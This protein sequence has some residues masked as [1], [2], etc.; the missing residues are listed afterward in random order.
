MPD[1]LSL[2]E[3]ERRFLAQELHDGMTQSLLQVNMQ[4]SICK[5]YL[6]MG[7]HAE[8]EKELD[9]LESQVH[10][11]SNQLRQLTSDLRPPLSSDG[12]FNAILEKQIETHLQRGGPPVNLTQSDSATL[13][14]PKRL[15][16]ARIS[17]EILNNIRKHAKATQ[18]DVTLTRSQS[19]YENPRHFPGCPHWT[20]GAETASCRPKSRHYVLQSGTNPGTGQAN[21]V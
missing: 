11:V 9:A 10:T 18:V 2:A 3:N 19:R 13:S 7:L 15:A 20:G 14:G 1:P 17:Q 4:A 16:L 6:S 12:S 21:A 5:Q 8:L